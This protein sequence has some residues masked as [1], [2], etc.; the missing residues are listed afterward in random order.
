MSEWSAKRFWK[1]AD[2]V[3]Q[4]G[5]FSVVLD[6]RN[7][8]TPAKRTLL[9]PTSDLARGI[10]DE[11]AAQG[12][13]VDPLSMPLTRAANAA[14][15]K[16]AVQKF[17]VSEL[18][19]EYGG[20]DLLCYRAGTPKRLVDRQIAAWDPILEWGEAT[21]GVTF[22]RAE[23]IVHQPQP[24]ETMR[25]LSKIIHNQGV[26][27]L[28]ALHDLVS[29]SGSL[30]VGLAAQVRAFPINDLWQASVLDESFQI[31]EWGQD[32]IATE[33]MANKESSFKN[34]AKLQTLIGIDRQVL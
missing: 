27:S 4:D 25:I 3:E 12:E 19:T 28:T 29:L 22:I 34:A 18:I 8:K 5:Q 2:F 17:E 20:S 24:A 16:V 23:G 33:M 21:F 32:D 30:I 26:F 6:G 13:K 7:V 1:D 9:V 11:W 10:A 14:I 15:D 31:E